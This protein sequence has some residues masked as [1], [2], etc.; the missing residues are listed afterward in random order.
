MPF[1][2]MAQHSGETFAC[3]VWVKDALLALQSAGLI[4]L[5]ESIEGIEASA[6]EKGEE[7]RRPVE[8]GDSSALVLNSTASST[9]S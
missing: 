7:M 1:L 3:R 8:L 6:I 9:P 4:I 5:F 2:P